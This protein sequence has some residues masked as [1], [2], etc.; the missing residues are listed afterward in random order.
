MDSDLRHSMLRYYDERASEY[1]EAYVLGTG[2]ASIADPEV[3]RRE[4][5]LLTQMVEHFARGRLVDL[6]CG[7]GYWLPYYV[8][9]CSSVTLIDQAP[10]MLQECRK[11]IASLDALDRITIIQ[12]DVLEHSFRPR[13]FDSALVGF[14]IS[15]LTDEEEQQLFERLKTMLDT[16]GRFLILDS[17]W[18]PERARFN[19]KTERQERRLNDGSRFEIYKRYI[20]RQDVV[21]WERKYGVATSIEHFGTAFIAVSGH[22]HE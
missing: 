4:A 16:D 20:D 8:A 13:A 9:G 19:R 14:L 10:R 17:A 6:A 22:V 5:L 15:H 7:T 2:T 21:E 11:K 1:E 12:D 18:S 3:F